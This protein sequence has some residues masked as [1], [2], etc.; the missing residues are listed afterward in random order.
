MVTI[1]GSDE[2]VDLLDCG[3]YFTVYLIS[4]NQVVF[5]KIYSFKLSIIP[6]KS[7]GEKQCCCKTLKK[8][9][10]IY[11]SSKKLKSPY[12]LTNSIILPKVTI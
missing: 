9:E 2:Y 11:L 1:R 4:D 8:S 10:S 12:F 6:Q 3:D 7:W 5:L